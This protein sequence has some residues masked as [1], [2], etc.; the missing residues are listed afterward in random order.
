MASN[1]LDQGAKV[2]LYCM[3]SKARVNK[4]AVFIIQP[5]TVTSV[6][7]CPSWVAHTPSRS[8][9]SS[10]GWPAGASAIE[11]RRANR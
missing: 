2:P 3:R 4:A 9:K 10:V 11:G 5:N 7:T 6:A 8:S 1:W